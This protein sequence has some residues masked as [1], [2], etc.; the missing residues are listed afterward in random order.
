MSPLVDGLG[1]RR[2]L[3]RD[4]W[5]APEPFGPDG[6]SYLAKDGSGI[7]L[8]TGWYEADGVAWIHASMSRKHHVPTYADLTTMH[9]AVWGKHGY[10]F[11]VFPPAHKHVNIHERVLHLWGRADGA[12]CLPDFARE[13]SI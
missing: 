4:V 6:Y 12:N 10:S 3:G 9:R 7:L 2:R 11:Q 8:V 5:T 13:G 1:I